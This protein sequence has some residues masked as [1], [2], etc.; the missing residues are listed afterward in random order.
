VKVLFIIDTQTID[1]EPLGLMHISAMLKEHGHE[2]EAV[3]L[4]R[5]ESN[6][7][8]SVK[9]IAPQVIAFSAVTGPHKKLLDSARA[10]K[11]DL[12]VIT[13]FGGPHPT[14]FPEFI[15]EEGVDV[16]CVGEGEYPTLELITALEKDEDFKDIANL[17]VKHEG[18]VYRNPPRPFVEDL[19]N[20]PWPD[21]DIFNAFPELHVADTRYFMGGRGCPYNCTFCFNHIAKQVAEGRYVR[22]RSEKDLI[23]E[24][25]HVKRNYGMRFANFQDDTFILKRTW[26]KNFSALYRDRIG[27]PFLCHVRANL[28]DVEVSQFL[29]SAGCV[30]VGMGLESGNDYLRNIVL[31]KGVS[32]EQLINACQVLHDSDITISTQNMFGVPFE[33]I[34]TVLDTI[35]LNIACRPERTNLFFYVPY[36]RTRLAEIAVEEGFYNRNILDDIPNLFNVEF[37]S[38]NLDLAN[39]EQIEQLAKLTRFCVHYPIFF[40]LIRALFKQKGFNWLK[41]IVSDS[42]LFLQGLYTKI[43]GGSVRLVRPFE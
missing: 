34:D 27:V 38:V 42:L 35:A 31:D 13:L 17:W 4:K 16:I 8:D 22:W 30:H 37:S 40:P 23:R 36:P 18:Q 7:L 29:A 32:R 12:D 10:I 28:V 39:A 25:E 19:D 11:R 21:R 3:D 24:L 14:F 41:S 33:T 6:L 2:V 9:R 20:L 15:E 43:V 1:Q 5:E 26:V